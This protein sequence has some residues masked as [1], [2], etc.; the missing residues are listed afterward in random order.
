ME[1][2]IIVNSIIKLKKDLLANIL[3]TFFATK[4]IKIDKT[5]LKGLTRTIGYGSGETEVFDGVQVEGTE[6]I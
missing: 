3:Y 6:E 2:K 5:S 1:S 4:G